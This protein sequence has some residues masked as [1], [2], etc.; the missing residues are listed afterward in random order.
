[1]VLRARVLD[2]SRVLEEQSRRSQRRSQVRTNER[3]EKIRTYNFP[4]VRVSLYGQAVR[5]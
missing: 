4:Q 2:H 5:L 1:M 3:S